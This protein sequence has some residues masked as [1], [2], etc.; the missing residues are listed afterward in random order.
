MKKVLV[1]IIIGLLGVVGYQMK[2]VVELENKL[3]EKDKTIKEY[4]CYECVF[5]GY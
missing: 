2:Q 1:I 3:I 5:Q 4:K